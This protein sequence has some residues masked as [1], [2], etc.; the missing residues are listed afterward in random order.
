MFIAT[1]R[2]RSPSTC[3]RVDRFADLPDFGV[4]QLVDAALGLD[5]DLLADFLGFGRADAVN[6]LQRDDD[7]LLRSEC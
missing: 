6:V 7:A 2:R 3:S 1:S 4:R 5:A